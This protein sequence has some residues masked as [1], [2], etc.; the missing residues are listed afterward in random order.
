MGDLVEK[1][2]ISK[3]DLEEFSI[4]LAVQLEELRH[5]IKTPE[6]SKEFFSIGAELEVS[7][8]DKDYMP[9]CENERLLKAVDS[10]NLTLELNK[11]NLEIN[12]TPVDPVG[13]PFFSLEKEL[14]HFLELLRKKGEEIGVYIV[15]AGILPTVQKHHVEREYMTDRPRYHAM[16]QN[17]CGIRGKKYKININGKDPLSFEGE[18]VTVEGANT[19][20]QVHLRVPANR[21]SNYFNAAQLTA[22][23]VLAMTANSP[24][25][26]GHRLWQESRIA[27]FKQSLDFR[28]QKNASWRPPSRVAFGHGWLRSSA[29]ELFAENVA[30]YEPL[31]PT[32]F[33]DDNCVPPKLAELCL[34]HGTIWPWNRGIYSGGGKEGHLRIEY[35]YMPA[36]PSLIDMIANTAL[37]IGFTLGL[38]EDID[39]Y[40]ARLPFQFAQYNFYRSAQSGLSANL[41]WPHKYRGGV[42]ERPVAGLIEEF[43]PLA[44]KGLQRMKLDKKDVDRL[45]KVMEERFDKKTSGAD[46]QVRRFE[47]YL[48][49]CSAKESCFRLLKDYQENVNKNIPVAQ[50]S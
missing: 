33:E 22:P 7:L 13:T 17:L 18:G 29:W 8:I 12:A 20:F 26:L 49:S 25:F 34:H 35:R 43:L 36:G 39:Y 32:L 19:S 27:L 42:E 24:V 4:R 1:Q 3:K 2:N 40:V 30:L 5:Q 31:L 37:V 15:A 6:F 23:L 11:Y 14:D 50:W 28:D 16:E 9:A 48:K 47:H 45:W 44:Y 41:V 38:E 10:P 21:F 46:W